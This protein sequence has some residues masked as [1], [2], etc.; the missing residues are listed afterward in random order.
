MDKKCILRSWSFSSSIWGIMAYR[1]KMRARLEPE[2]AVK[3]IG[4]RIMR[5]VTKN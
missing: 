2:K 4:I 3:Y 1:C 5:K